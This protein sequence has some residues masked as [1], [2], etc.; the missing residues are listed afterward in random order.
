MPISR[1]FTH[2]GATTSSG[3][4]PPGTASRTL[5]VN[6]RMRERDTACVRHASCV[7]QL[8]LRLLSQEAQAR[9]RGT[10]GLPRTFKRQC[11][12]HSIAPGW[13][14]LAHL[15]RQLGPR[16]SWR[17]RAPFCALWAAAGC[18]AGCAARACASPASTSPRCLPHRLACLGSRRPPCTLP[19]PLCGQGPSVQ[20]QRRPHRRAPVGVL[21]PRPPSPPAGTGEH[22]G[23]PAL[24]SC[25]TTLP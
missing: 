21:P 23:G 19:Q 6:F 8:A 25:S 14:A 15:A 12:E 16:G 22:S 17:S 2:G 7:T 18:A 3:S 13:Q 4:A 1:R 5:Y 9:R 11:S 20:A 24:V 10:G